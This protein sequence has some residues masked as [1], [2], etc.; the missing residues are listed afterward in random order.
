M[1]PYDSKMVRELR[2]FDRMQVDEKKNVKEKNS[3]EVTVEDR[4][5]KRNLKI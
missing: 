1:I 5:E 2:Y 4:S 3:R